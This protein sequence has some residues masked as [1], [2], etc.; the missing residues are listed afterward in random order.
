[1]VTSD[2]V[3]RIEA[4]SGPQ[5]DPLVKAYDASDTGEMVSRMMAIMEVWTTRDPE[6]ETYQSWEE[7]LAHALVE[8]LTSEPEVETATVV[9]F[10]RDGSVAFSF[11]VPE[12]GVRTLDLLNEMRRG[13]YTV[14][15]VP[16]A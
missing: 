3:N 2:V 16:R 13:R 1:V 15:L 5:L 6:T 14:K 4:E 8:G 10:W 12:G 7:S 11:G 9:E